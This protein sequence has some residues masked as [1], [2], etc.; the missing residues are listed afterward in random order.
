MMQQYVIVE[1]VTQWIKHKNLEIFLMFLLNVL[2]YY[3]QLQQIIFKV[4]QFS[5]RQLL[6]KSQ[7]KHF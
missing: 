4:F 2:Q 6:V 1:K 7:N 3:L 5:D